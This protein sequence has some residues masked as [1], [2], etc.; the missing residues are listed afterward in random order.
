M[1][2][3]R[4]DRL[5]AEAKKK[6]CLNAET[7]QMAKE[8]GLNPKSLIKNIPS[9]QQQW[10]DPVHVWIRDMYQKRQEKMTKKALQKNKEITD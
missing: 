4:K 9:P 2:K 8:M 5:W 7:V 3:E 6:C 1:D 10:K